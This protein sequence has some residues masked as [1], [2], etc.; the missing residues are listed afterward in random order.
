MEGGTARTE[1]AASALRAH[2]SD[3]MG[4]CHGPATAAPWERRRPATSWL[5]G[6][7]GLEEGNALTGLAMQPGLPRA[8]GDSPPGEHPLGFENSIQ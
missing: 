3:N 5:P 2:A 8:R 1:P 4:R 6:S 7:R